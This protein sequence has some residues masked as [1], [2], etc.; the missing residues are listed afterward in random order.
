MAKTQLTVEL[1]R[2]FA[3]LLINKRE[4][5]EQIKGTMDNALRSF[6]WDDPIAHKFKNDYE[7]Q[8]Q[9]LKT[10]LLPA[11]VKYEDYLKKLSG[12]SDVYTENSSPSSIDFK[13][14]AA[15]TA[16][17]SGVTVVAGSMLG[18]SPVN[19]ISDRWKFVPGAKGSFSYNNP[20]S[21]V[22]GGKF[23]YILD[24]NG[25]C[26]GVFDGTKDK[27][28]NE[29]LNDKKEILNHINRN[30]YNKEIAGNLKLKT[31]H[32]GGITG[33]DVYI[34]DN[35]RDWVRQDWWGNAEHR[36][37]NTDLLLCNPKTGNI[38]KYEALKFLSKNPDSDE[39]YESIRYVPEKELGGFFSSSP[40]KIEGF[41]LT[42]KAINQ[43]LMDKKYGL[44]EEHYQYVGTYNYAPTG[45][46]DVGFVMD[47]GKDKI[48]FKP[49]ENSHY[50]K[51]YTLHTKEGYNFYTQPEK[52]TK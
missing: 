25:R 7:T 29:I 4:S 44:T 39:V 2:Q 31:N 46:R 43:D 26:I 40:Q 27:N 15:T 45:S 36:P 13:T 22:K 47:I 12:L 28:G 34:D 30:E 1:L 49:D 42:N 3:Q 11:M 33:R 6:L 16:A 21:K 20:D 24:K 19:N 23:E 38:E 37:K 32:L 18:G 8:M 14:A 17:V 51:D 10:K 5:F 48:G 35:K 9:P 52:I 50:S 41:S